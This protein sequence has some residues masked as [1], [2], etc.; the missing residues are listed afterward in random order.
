M[1]GK[2]QPPPIQGNTF[3]DAAQQNPSFAWQ[4][5]FELIPPAINSPAASGTVPTK[6]TSQGIAGQ[7]ATDG[8]FLYIAI[9]ANSWKKIPLS[10]L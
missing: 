3:L 9:G 5:W 6:T 10:S 4:R 2:F 8:E 7:M 1:A